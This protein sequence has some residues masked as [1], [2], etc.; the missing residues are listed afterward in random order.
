MLCY[1][2]FLHAAKR[3]NFRVINDGWMDGWMD[4]IREADWKRASAHVVRVRKLVRK[5]ISVEHKA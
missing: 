2:V 4:S 5:D 1:A 3:Q